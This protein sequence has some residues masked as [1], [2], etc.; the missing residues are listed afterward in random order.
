MGLKISNETERERDGEHFGHFSSLVSLDFVKCFV[1]FVAER[2]IC[3]RC[4][5][6]LF[7][8]RNG[9]HEFLH[10]LFL[11]QRLS[12]DIFIQILCYNV[13]PAAIRPEQ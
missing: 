11:S 10:N 12:C 5:E 6:S 4:N 7:S 9:R 1:S 13:T 3:N 8:K 2:E